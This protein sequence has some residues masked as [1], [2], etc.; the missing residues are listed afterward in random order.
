MWKTKINN[1]CVRA[2]PGV[3]CLWIVI[4]SLVV[5]GSPGQTLA[6]KAAFSGFLRDYSKLKP[7]PDV[8]G[9]LSY[10]N[11]SRGLKHYD[12]FL[13]DR[14]IVHF[15]PNAKGTGVDPMKL[16]Q[17]TDYAHRELVIALS[18]RYQVVSTPGPGVLRIRVAITSIKTTKPLFNIHPGMK[19]IGFGLGGAS[20]EAEGVDSQTGERIIAVVDSRKGAHSPIP[21]V[22]ALEKL[23]H[24]KEVIRYWVKRFRKRLDKAHGFTN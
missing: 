21:S 24:V 4:L 13:I 15:A 7:S 6:R 17:I 1:C 2:I 8:D 11:P 19:V 12:K 9:A 5:L 14:I 10:E 20:M 23:G 3:A 16:V 22:E 18:K